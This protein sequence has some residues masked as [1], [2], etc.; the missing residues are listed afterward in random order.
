MKINIY[1]YISERILKVSIILFKAY[2][3]LKCWLIVSKGHLSAKQLFL[4]VFI[5]NPFWDE[6]S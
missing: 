6:A 3:S 5:G 2:I 1:I 4:I